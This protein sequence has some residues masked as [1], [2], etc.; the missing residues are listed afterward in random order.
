MLNDVQKFLVGSARHA[1]EFNH[2]LIGTRPL[3]APQFKSATSGFRISK[4]SWDR[5]RAIA[6]WP[7]VLPSHLARRLVVKSRRRVRRMLAAAIRRRQRNQ[8]AMMLRTGAEAG[9][10][11][12]RLGLL[13]LEPRIVFDA[14]ATATAE[15]AADQV[16]EQ[17]AQDAV[18]TSSDGGGDTG[19]TD[20]SSDALL[21]DGQTTEQSGFYDQTAGLDFDAFDAAMPVTAVHEIAFVD[22][23][24]ENASELIAALPS[25]V[26]II[27][28][29][30][31]RDGV[32]QIASIL[33]GMENLDAIHILSH[34]SEGSLSLGSATLDA[35]SMQ[36]E[37]IDELA[38]IGH[39]LSA[40]GDILIYGCDFTTGDKGLQAAMILG[41]IT[42]ADI[43]ASIDPTG[44][45]DLG[46]DWD[47]ETN[48]GTIDETAFDVSVW[49]GLLAAPVANADG[50]VSMV[51]GVE[52]TIDVLANDTDADGNTRTITGIKDLAHPNAAALSIATG[53]T[54][55]LASGTTITL[56]ADKTL[57]VTMHPD[58]TSQEVFQYVISDGT[59]STATGNVTI[60]RDTDGDGIMDAVDTDDDNAGISDAREGLSTSRLDFAV[61]DGLAALAG[62]TKTQTYGTTNPD[63][64]FELTMHADMGSVVAYAN[65]PS[66]IGRNP[67]GDKSSIVLTL[68]GMTSTSQQN[69]VN[70]KFSDAV[71]NVSFV[72][73]DIDGGNGISNETVTFIGKLNGVTRI[74][75]PSEVQLLADTAPM[76]DGNTLSGEDAGPSN[77]VRITFKEK[78]DELQIIA[79]I[80]SDNLNTSTAQALFDLKFEHEKP[81]DTDGDGVA[82]HLDIDSDNDGITD[83]NETVNT[84]GLSAATAFQDLG[85]A[86]TVST[87]GLYYFNVDGHAFKTYV[88][89]N[90]YIL[91][92]IDFGDGP[93]A[94]PQT[95][96]LTN[97]SRGIL[98]PASLSALSGATEIRISSSNGAIDATSK[99]VELISRVAS[100]T[101]LKYS[102]TADNFM[103][104][105]WI[106]TGAANLTADG[107]AS[108]LGSS[109]DQNIFHASG[110][111]ASFIWVPGSNY[112]RTLFTDGEIL[113]TQ[114]LY[115]WVKAPTSPTRVD[116]KSDADVYANRVDIDSDNDGITDNIE[117]QTTAGYIAP[118]GMPGAGFT[119]TDHDGLDDNYD[120]NIS[121]FS[122]TTSVGLI[123]VDTDSDGKA[124]YIDTDSDND[125]LLDIA[126]RGDGQPKSVTSLT[127]TDRDGLLDLFEA[128]TI[129]DGFDVN[130]SNR[131][132]TTLSLNL[133]SDP[134][135]AADGSDATPLIKDA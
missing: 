38:I 63:V 41:G 36:G 10:A 94:L 35:T 109:L 4:R 50:P 123:P 133:A 40:D 84:D 13:A 53:Q 56:N 43:A 68:S 125:G 80:T 87:P 77:A 110:N 57:A 81:G 115:L 26:E 131:A 114:A 69:T 28:L 18:A 71:Q 37:Y 82:D 46:G 54:I 27:M 3:E 130:D 127:D 122:Q 73:A 45:A 20:S 22:G 64:T 134:F 44:S 97:L 32:E 31:S 111:S 92:A 106:G 129:N 96:N 11:S 104:D 83:T 107:A 6:R 105:F 55:T 42:G 58:V 132:D 2:R 117:A 25:T 70:I 121:L 67:D 16:A 124:D 112:Q 85:M 29:D 59:G 86:G 14:A 34:G 48:I 61:A 9:E 88:D 101:S 17:Q 103:N 108:T 60:I 128:G 21:A 15:V 30:P 62:E 100:N 118:S 5:I 19:A 93:G 49:Y 66:F 76:Q 113:S 119:D 120:A 135:L 102:G 39:A 79:G 74:L 78:I 51:G 116:V 7:K 52:R 47:L 23:S 24:V 90:G 91:T 33:D 1:S 98:D 75:T 95:S 72:Y 99:D 126:E 89:G 65:G 8:H 12:S